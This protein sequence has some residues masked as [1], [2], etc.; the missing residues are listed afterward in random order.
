MLVPV[1]ALAVLGLAS[2]CADQTDPAAA[3]VGDQTLRTQDLLDE[4]EAIG[5]NEDMGLDVAGELR[6]SYSQDFVSQVLQ[7]RVLF[8]LYEQ[9]ADDEGI[10]ATDDNRSQAT[11]YFESGSSNEFGAAFA[12][13]P[14]SYQEQSIDDVALAMAVEA[15]LG[16]SFTAELSDL[17]D[18][19]EIAARFGT[20]DAA[21]FLGGQNGVLAP[22][23]PYLRSVE[24]R[25]ADAAEAGDAGGA[26]APGA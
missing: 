20:W 12:S 2:G 23:G 5:G 26:A 17:T 15:E 3:T 19:V 16:E 25:E 10:E 22:D 21:A 6:G 7:R 1:A 9:V 13:L 18:D 8:M 14:E 24:E 11:Q 4:V